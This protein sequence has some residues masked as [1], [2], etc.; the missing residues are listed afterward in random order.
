[1]NHIK[2][3]VSSQ[4]RTSEL[5][6]ARW[7]EGNAAQAVFLADLWQLSCPKHGQ[8]KVAM[9]GNSTFRDVGGLVACYYNFQF[10]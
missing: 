3:A 9:G 7:T 5:A 2:Y 6:D 4:G 8:E 1:M 10:G